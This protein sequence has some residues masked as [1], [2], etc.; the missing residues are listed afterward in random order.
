MKIIAIKHY[1]NSC[2]VHQ[3]FALTEMKFAVGSQQ[4]FAG[5]EDCYAEDV[6]KT[7]LEN[8]LKTYL[9]NV[10]KTCL[11][12]VFKTYWKQTNLNVSLI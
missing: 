11:E 10:L 8:V 6:L 3:N 4:I 7:C 12:D 1:Y 9:E 2:K 5:L